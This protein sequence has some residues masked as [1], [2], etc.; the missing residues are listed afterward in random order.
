VEQL[1][2]FTWTAIGV[3]RI[4]LS[5]IRRQEPQ[6]MADKLGLALVTLLRSARVDQG[7]YVMV[8]KSSL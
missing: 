3:V 1:R 4:P 2:P 5:E 7:S 8:L 6:P